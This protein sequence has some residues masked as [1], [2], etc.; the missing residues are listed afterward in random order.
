MWKTSY[1]SASGGKRSTSRDGAAAQTTRAHL[2]SRERRPSSAATADSSSTI[3]TT[4]TATEFDYFQS[5]LDGSRE[6]QITAVTSSSRSNVNSSSNNNNSTSVARQQR[7]APPPQPEPRRHVA[8]PMILSSMTTNRESGPP[9][10]PPTA[11]S[12]RSPP[13]PQSPSP[14]H[15][16]ILLGRIGSGGSNRSKR[17]NAEED[18]DDDD[19]D[20]VLFDVA[21]TVFTRNLFLKML[22]AAGRRRANRFADRHFAKQSLA[23]IRILPSPSPSSASSSSLGRTL[24][25]RLFNKWQNTA[26]VLKE[27]R[28]AQFYCTSLL[29]TAFS[30]WKQR[31]ATETA[32]A[33]FHRSL[34]PLW[35]RRRCHQLLFTWRQEIVARRR[36]PLVRSV[37]RVWHDKAATAHV[38]T[39][40]AIALQLECWRRWRQRLRQRRLD[41]FAAQVRRR[42]VLLRSF[43]CW[44][45]KGDRRRRAL[46][47]AEARAIFLKRR[48]FYYWRS[49]HNTL[50]TERHRRL[51]DGLGIFV[52][53]PKE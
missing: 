28:A 3:T 15:S 23:K 43:G 17:R 24:Q 13:S 33:H 25:R 12:S 50:V 7:V 30:K 38:V 34:Q 16:V 14:F 8:L 11:S 36:L 48:S 47:E 27:A 51:E 6:S 29:V 26:L 35:R 46:Q 53:N 40:M 4:P 2:Q 37:F 5:V 49:R 9:F 18:G 52:V 42:V 21:Q 31:A 19:G 39:R 20:D 1:L 32:L 22:V 44:R 10:A 41:L 45:E